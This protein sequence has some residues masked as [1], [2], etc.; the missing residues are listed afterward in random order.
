MYFAEVQ[1][2]LFGEPASRTVF[3]DGVIVE[4][5]SP[6]NPYAL[7]YGSQIPTRYKILYKSRWRRVYVICYSNSGSSYV[8]DKGNMHSVDVFEITR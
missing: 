4:R 5:E 3:A 8:F 6:P 2:S 7:G 1:Q